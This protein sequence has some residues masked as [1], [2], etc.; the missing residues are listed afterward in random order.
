MLGCGNQDA[1]AHQ[2]GG[3]AYFLNVTP[4]GGNLE[5][6]QIAANKDN[7]GGW[8]RWEDADTDG[9]A[10]VKPHAG[11][12]DGPL[13]RRLK[14]QKCASR[15][16]LNTCLGACINPASIGTDDIVTTRSTLSL[17]F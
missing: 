10:R 6:A 5:T 17:A 11:G 3:V 9:N 15:A 1:L 7:T 2:A 14:S 8:G 13:D 12:R 16:S 4:A